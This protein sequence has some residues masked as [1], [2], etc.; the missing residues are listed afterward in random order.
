MQSNRQMLADEL[1]AYEEKAKGL[2]SYVRELKTM[3]A[4]H[5]TPKE[6]FESDLLKAMHNI[7]FYEAE[8]ARLKNQMRTPLQGVKPGTVGTLLPKTRNQG[9]GAV[10]LSSISFAAGT[11]LGS[12][13]NS[14]KSN[15][16]RESGN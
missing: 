7:V 8:I 1:E 10:I 15:K 2:T 12:L 13:M 9:I 4:K 5:D 11:I 6:R 3:T 14:G 16:D